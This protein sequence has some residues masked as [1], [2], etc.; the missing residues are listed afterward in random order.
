[1]GLSFTSRNNPSAL[2]FLILCMLTCLDSR[3]FKIPML[4]FISS[5]SVSLPSPFPCTGMVGNHH[6]KLM[7]ICMYALL[8]RC[9]QR[10][11]SVYAYDERRPTDPFHPSMGLFLHTIGCTSWHL[12]VSIIPLLPPR[13]P[14]LFI[15]NVLDSK[16]RHLKSI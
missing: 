7:Y 2:F 6:D 8:V 11:Q 9:A 10:F 16:R 4:V 13:L 12:K 1:M 5:P 14:L 3:K 15:S